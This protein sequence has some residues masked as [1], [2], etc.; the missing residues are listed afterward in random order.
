MDGWKIIKQRSDV[1]LPSGANEGGPT[2][3]YGPEV[4]SLLENGGGEVDGAAPQE[5]E[6]VENESTPTL[7]CLLSSVALPRKKPTLIQS[8]YGFM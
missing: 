8:L 7:P 2:D 6:L 3:H 1:V 5:A 4:P